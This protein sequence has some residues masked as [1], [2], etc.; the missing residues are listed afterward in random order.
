MY[1]RICLVCGKTFIG[2]HG[3]ERMCGDECRAQRKRFKNKGRKRWKPTTTRKTC[4]IC[5]RQFSCGHGQPRRLKSITCSP[6][7]SVRNKWMVVQSRE[8]AARALKMVP[9]KA[10][11]KLF[12]PSTVGWKDTCSEQCENH[13]RRNAESRRREARRANGTA[14]ASEAR[15]RASGYMK[16]YKRAWRRRRAESEARLELMLITHAAADALYHP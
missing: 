5:K 1:K 8:K 10:C 7:C 11:G 2:T 15:R 6:E 9:C 4:V 3:P 16:N 14:Q 12:H 13:H